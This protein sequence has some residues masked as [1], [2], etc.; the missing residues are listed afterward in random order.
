MAAISI[1]ATM[2]LK[3]M[4]IVQHHQQQPPS[5]RTTL[6][7]LC[8]TLRFTNQHRK[9]SFSRIRYA[10][11]N[12]VSVRLSQVQHLLH[13]AEERA[14]PIGNDPPP[15][16]TLDHVT[17]SFARSGGPGGQNVHK[18]NHQCCFLCPAPSFK[19]A[20]EENCQDGCYWGAETPYKKTLRRNRNSWD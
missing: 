16:I 13:K 19:R 17:V 20:K 4:F 3:E 2:I 11:D 14:D 9:I 15:K 7:S 10:A 1:S 6:H 12:K 5:L 18:G 8:T